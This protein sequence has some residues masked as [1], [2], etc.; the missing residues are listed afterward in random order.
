[1]DGKDSKDYDDYV[2][3]KSVIVEARA[4][5]KREIW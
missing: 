1:M 4:K 2:D 3:L 5:G